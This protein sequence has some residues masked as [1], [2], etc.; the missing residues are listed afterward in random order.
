M[1]KHE[2]YPNCDYRD[3]WGNLTY[4]INKM[5]MIFIYV[6]IHIGIKKEKKLWYGFRVCFRVAYI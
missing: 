5:D 1:E 3:I 2:L 4:F 6:K